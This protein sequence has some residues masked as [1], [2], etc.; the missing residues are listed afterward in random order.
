MRKILICGVGGIGKK[1]IDGFLKTGKFK[2]SVC[3]ID[4]RKLKETKKNF[5]IEDTYIDF[6][7]VDIEKFDAVLISTPA[8]YHIKMALR[9][10][11]KKV[12]FL[13]EKPLSLN[14]KNVNKLLESVERNKVKCA[15]GFTRRSIPP[16]IKFRELIKSKKSGKIK[17]AIFY[18]A[19]DYRKYRPDYARIYFAREKMGGGCILDDVSHFVDLAQWYIGNPVYGKGIYDN[20]DFGRKV[21]TEDSTVI[22]SRFNRTI[23]NFYCNLFQKPYEVLIEF[24][25]TKG[26]LRYI[27]E[28]RNISKILFS[29]NDKG[30][31]KELYLF[32]NETKDYYFYQAENFLKLL[33]GKKNTLTTLE[34]AIEN[35]KFCLKIKRRGKNGNRKD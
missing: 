20:L 3:D 19:Q 24:A 23:V 1:H 25:G 11:E 17:M 27:S 29:D 18:V 12:P 8:N 7:K 26:N 4:E 16:F 22:V 13:V 32:K 21:E 31:W 35:L 33:E 28:N 5:K 14:L 10:A 34:E 2:I 9:C 15:V 6:F 30:K